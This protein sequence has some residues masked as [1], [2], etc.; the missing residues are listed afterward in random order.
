MKKYSFW[1]AIGLISM[2]ISSCLERPVD[3]IAS[4]NTPNIILIVADDIGYADLSVANLSKDVSTPNIDN[5]ANRG[6]RFTQSYATSPICSPSRA[7]LITGVHQQR[8][9]TYF[10]GGP[11][12][13]NA[14]YK[15]LP[16]ILKVEGYH[17]GYVGKVHYG[18]NDNDTTH[19]S[20]P[21]NHG[22]DYFFGTMG[23][24]K[25]YLIHSDK[26]EAQFV[27][28]MKDNNKK[29]Q[30]LKMQ[31]FW[32][33]KERID[34]TGFS[35]E[36]FGGEAMK[37]VSKH[38]NEKFFM[39]LSF[40]AV[41]NFTHQ[42]PKNYLEKNGLQGYH[43]WDPN[44]EDYLEWYYE[45]RFPNNP[46]GRAHYLGQLN[47]LDLEIGKLVEHLEKE[48]IADNTLIIFIGDNGGST[49]IYANN[50][51]LRGSK[52]VLYEG[53]IRVP[54]IINYPSVYQPLVSNEVVS[55]MD[56]L[57]TICQILEIET[58]DNV[59]GRDISTILTQQSNSLITDTLIWD[60]GH[61]YA[62]RLGE[63]K[64]HVASSTH[65][66]DY[67]GVELE[68]GT[69]L[70]NL[71]KDPSESTDLSEINPEITARL[72]GIY[73]KWKAEIETEISILEQQ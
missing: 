67:E 15:T 44:T 19:R 31:G 5:L 37:Y 51:P 72:N 48:G 64:L 18:K 12:M 66:A 46:E 8:W 17:T 34:T 50:G 45:G 54:I 63:W 24:R 53:G 49:P 11:G 71:E 13:R 35:T 28:S 70:Y 32:R 10:Y 56:L 62:L 27:Q 59:D 65:S 21:N 68:L 30:S 3:E 23:G 42:L 4:E 69:H 40:N 57:P 61:E 55:A 22:F 29:G 1:F 7:G 2:L 16:E 36:I 41:H 20:F 6:V 52:Y 73:K 60:S 47:Y 25:H 14:A 39:Q 43:D 33:N 26:T 58:P 9:G 38:K